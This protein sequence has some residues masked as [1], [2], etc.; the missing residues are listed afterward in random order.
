MPGRRELPLLHA[1][2]WSLRA[3]V[4]SQLR[5]M[6]AVQRELDALVLLEGPRREAVVAR[7]IA[8]IEQI[9][10]ANRT[11]RAL[12]TQ[13]LR[14]ARALVPKRSTPSTVKE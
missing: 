13:T 5:N 9:I 6:T 11:I 12:S 4:E 7:L 10:D 2:L 14:S 1:H 3:E 8:D